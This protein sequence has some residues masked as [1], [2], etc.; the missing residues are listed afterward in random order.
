MT[1]INISA[2]T[3]KISERELL[4]LCQDNPETRFETTPTGKLIVIPPTGSLT[5]EKNS[6]LLIQVG[7]WNRQTKLGVCRA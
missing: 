7:I 5:G 6:D 3:E 1:A 2:F 4:K